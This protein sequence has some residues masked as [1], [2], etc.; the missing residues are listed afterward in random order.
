MIDGKE[1][2]NA[3]DRM[4]EML[5]PE[6]A[7]NHDAH[8]NALEADIYTHPGFG[9]YTEVVGKTFGLSNT[10]Y[11]EYESEISS[12]IQISLDEGRP[13]AILYPNNRREETLEY[14]DYLTDN[15]NT[16]TVCIPT[17]PLDSRPVTGSDS[18]GIF[19]GEKRLVKFLNG[20][21]KGAKINLYG[22]LRNQCYRN[23][24][25]LIN[26]TSEKAGMD[27]DINQETSFPEGVIIP[28]AVRN[29]HVSPGVT[30]DAIEDIM[31]TLHTP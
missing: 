13:I 25:W 29:I 4:A 8:E 20:L 28:L 10:D 15:Q 18:S 5:E 22:E 9:H 1:F 12:A 21:Q 24:E 19:S 26:E 23:S 2:R 31:E 11:K 6:N 17:N 16:E 27:F 7:R 30:G 14:I 3:S